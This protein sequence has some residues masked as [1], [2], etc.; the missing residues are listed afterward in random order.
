VYLDRKLLRRE[1][2][3]DE[4]FRIVVAHASGSLEPDL[5]NWGQPYGRVFEPL[6]KVVPPPRLMDSLS[7]KPMG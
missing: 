3:F 4:Q 5:A 2:I 6:P 7:P 1:E